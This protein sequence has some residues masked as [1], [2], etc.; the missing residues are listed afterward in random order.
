MD[1]EKNNAPRA[2]G[3]MPREGELDCSVRYSDEF[4]ERYVQNFHPNTKKRPLY[5]F[6]KRAFDILFAIFLLVL[7]SPVMLLI[8]IAIKLDSRGPVIFKQQRVGKNGKLFRCYKFRSMKISAP[9]AVPTSQMA[10]PEVYVTRVGWVLRKLSLDEL[11]Q[12]FCCLIGTM[13]FI[14]PRPLVPSEEK[15]HAMR[16]SLGVYRMRPGISGYAQ[17]NGRDNVYYKNKAIL[18]AQYVRDA[19]L[20]LDLKLLLLTVIV[21]FRRKGNNTGKRVGKNRKDGADGE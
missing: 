14:G 3:A 21:V 13:S 4:Y 1:I 9:D 18:D 19:S 17:V 6:I 7:L 2:N 11:P 10:K 20:W 12:L 5:R 16:E 8:A 15:C